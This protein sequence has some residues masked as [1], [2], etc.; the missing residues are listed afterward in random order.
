M[1]GMVHSRTLVL[2]TAWISVR[3][4]RTATERGAEIAVRAPAAQSQ[5]YLDNVG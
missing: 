2:Q 5:T 1:P 4:V 3:F